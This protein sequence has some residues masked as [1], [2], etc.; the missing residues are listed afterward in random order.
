M[1]SG[2][3]RIQTCLRAERLP[4]GSGV[5]PLVFPQSRFCYTGALLAG[6]SIFFFLAPRGIVAQ[7]TTPFADP[8]GKKPYAYIGVAMAPL[9]PNVAQRYQLPPDRRQGVLVRQV[10]PDG[11]AQKAGLRPGDIIHSVDGDPV[12]ETYELL[13][14]IAYRPIGSEVVLDLSRPKRGL[15]GFE[16]V[17]ARMTLVE[18][19]DGAD[20]EAAVERLKDPQL[21]E[22][23]GAD[24][25]AIGGLSL[26][27]ASDDGSREGLRVFS[28]VPNSEAA[29]AGFF[30]GDLILEIEG[31][32][33]NTR[34]D[35]FAALKE[36]TEDTPVSVLFLRD[37]QRRTTHWAVTDPVKRTVIDGGQIE[38][39]RETPES[40]PFIYDPTNGTISPGDLWGGVRQ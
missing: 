1:R 26:G 5:S 12:A 6:L 28:V 18:R 24:P 10:M 16:S 38:L 40:P 7:Q 20:V 23:I 27:P 22:P 37:G 8:D 15:R 9:T 4:S 34:A 32:A 3:N 31:T 11:P 30:Q 17:Q 21:L 35:V 25:L 2:A 36:A 33:V 13:E 39:R 14:A 29:M 19:T